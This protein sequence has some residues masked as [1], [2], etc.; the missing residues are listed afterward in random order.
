LAVAAGIL[1][2]RG[3]IFTQLPVTVPANGRATSTAFTL[4][5]L[6]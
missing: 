2:R 6:L 3:A 4:P 5:S 1:A